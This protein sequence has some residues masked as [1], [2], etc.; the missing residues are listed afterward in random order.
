MGGIRAVAAVAVAG[1]VIVGGCG[2][3]RKGSASVRGLS[4]NSR[5]TQSTVTSP[6]TTAPAVGTAQRIAAGATGLTVTLLRV[7]DPLRDSGA[8]LLPGSRAVGVML[9]IV[10]HGPGIYD[11]SATGDVSILGSSGTATP[12]FAQSG[13]CQTPLRDFDNYISPGEKRIGCV[14]FSLP[15]GARLLT[16]RFSPHA[17]AAGR[18]SWSVS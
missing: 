12:V 7:I 1:A 5:P 13:V 16:V 17:K 15:T 14:A 18:V 8:A 9:R 4:V 3:S 6:P 11:S 2:T 10:N